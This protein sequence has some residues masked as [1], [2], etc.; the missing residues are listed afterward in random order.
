MFSPYFCTP[1]RKAGTFKVAYFVLYSVLI[2]D[3]KYKMNW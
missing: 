1:L 2:K 3:K